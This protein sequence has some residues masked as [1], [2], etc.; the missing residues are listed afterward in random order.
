MIK[1]AVKGGFC[2]E[3]LK[4]GDDI[5][6]ELLR[7]VARAF[8]NGTDAEAAL[9]AAVDAF[10]ADFASAQEKM[11]ADMGEF[12]PEDLRKYWQNW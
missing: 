2:R 9:C 11:L 6:S 7:L 8:E 1:R 12:S 5:G 3:M 10:I 4:D